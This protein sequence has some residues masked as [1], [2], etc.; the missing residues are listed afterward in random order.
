MAAKQPMRR[1][2]GQTPEEMA[3]QMSEN[4]DNSKDRL[5]QNRKGNYKEVS[6]QLKLEALSASIDQ[7]M[8]ILREARKRGRV[9][10]NDID[11]VEAAALS[12][13]H[14]CKMAGVFP[15][16]LGFS[17]ACGYSRARLYSYISSNDNETAQY[18][19]NLR[20]SW[21]AII[22]QMSLARQCGEPTAIFLLKNAGQGMT[23]K[24]E[25]D[26]TGRSATPL[27]L[28]GISAEDIAARWAALPD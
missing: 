4:K 13:M 9:N 6:D 17:A 22:A 26:V 23:D 12:Y 2:A 5:Y 19:D 27:G 10:L 7:Q 18:L 24:A 1:E 11:E 3:E 28:D 14:S 15:S 20:C 8:Q 25:L 16:M 21:A